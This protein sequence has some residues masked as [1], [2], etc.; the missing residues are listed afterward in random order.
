M[1]FQLGD[2]WYA[3]F[4]LE[5]DHTKYINRPVIIVVAETPEVVVIKVT[6]TAPRRNDPYDVPIQH[7]IDAGLKHPS[8]AR[9]SKVI[10]VDESQIISKIGQL[11][12]ND[13]EIIIKKLIEFSNQ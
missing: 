12:P 1:K 5:E 4:P 2:V 7:F 9:V 8:T 13:L 3:D 10:T 6:K 11:H